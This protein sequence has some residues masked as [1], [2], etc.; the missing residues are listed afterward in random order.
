MSTAVAESIASLRTLMG[1]LEQ[2]MHDIDAGRLDADLEAFMMQPIP[3]E[4]QVLCQRLGVDIPAP[5]ELV[6]ALNDVPQAP[7][8]SSS[9]SS[10]SSSAPPDEVAPT[11]STTEPSNTT[12]EAEQDAEGLAATSGETEDPS[13]PQKRGRGRPPKPHK[14]DPL[15]PEEK[16]PVLPPVADPAPAPAPEERLDSPRSPRRGDHPV[17]SSAKTA[18]KTKGTEKESKG[19]A[20]AE[21][22]KEEP[23]RKHSPA[24]V[25]AAAAAV[26]GGSGGKK[27]KE[28]EEEPRRSK[29]IKS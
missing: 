13:A 4:Y 17:A 24:V 18:T 29:R 21:K 16:A 27:G 11:V 12:H 5:P 10:S 23:K 22:V 14:T 6:P 26:A 9:A 7:S 25:P 15:V 20:T 19:K 2:R 1:M 8:S 3:A 28:E